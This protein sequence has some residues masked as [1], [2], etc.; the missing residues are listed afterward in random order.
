[1]I[2]LPKEP[3]IEKEEGNKATFVIEELYPGYGVTVG[4]SLRRVLLSS[5][6]GSAI[7]EVR[8]E[9]A[10]HEFSAIKGVKEDGILI[11][12]NLK[13]VR[14]KMHEEG[15]FSATLSV[16]GEKEV[17]AGDFKT[18][19]QLE[20]VNKDH[21]IA[22]LTDKKASLDMEV[23]VTKGVGYEQ[24]DP[25]EEESEEIGAIRM[26]A[27]YTPV[28]RVSFKVENM[29]VGERTDFDR[30]ILTIETDG[31]MDPVDA[32]KGAVE[33][34]RK[35]FEA[36]EVKKEPKKK[37]SKKEKPSKKAE[38]KDP[39]DIDIDDLG[40]STRTANVLK[41]NRVKSLAGLVARSEENVSEMEGIGAKSMEEIKKMLS[42]KGLS[43]K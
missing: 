29:R 41:E 23:L 14:F 10:P 28:T 8:I 4:N 25:D 16:K 24:V 1:M 9:D 32:F 15:P 38:K 2:P 5:M 13:E 39:S 19:S 40:L 34:L 7:T 36:L 31:G 3:K 37:S 43:L 20:V 18:P 6:E 21:H 22:T 33:I 11:L 42:K 35:H 17:T 27:V 12:L 30:L 26:D